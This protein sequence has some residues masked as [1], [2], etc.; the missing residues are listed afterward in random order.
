[1]PCS[2]T[3]KPG[4]RP[5]LHSRH[6]WP[7]HN[8]SCAS[9][10]SQDQGPVTRSRIACANL[11]VAEVV[12]RGERPAPACAMAQTPA[13]LLHLEE[14]PQADRQLCRPQAAGRAPATVLALR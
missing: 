6:W 5:A 7:L 3:A 11:S 2:G 1:M 8:K 12:A 13:H 9:K 14:P 10:Q 4:S